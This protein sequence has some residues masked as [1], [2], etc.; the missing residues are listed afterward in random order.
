MSTQMISES[1]RQILGALQIVFKPN[2][3]I[4][5]AS[6]RF[7]KILANCILLIPLI[8]VLQTMAHAGASFTDNFSSYPQN[9]C[10]TDGMNFGPWTEIFGN[11]SPS[12]CVQVQSNG[13]QTW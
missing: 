3:M 9:A 2:G 10:F 11:Y 5:A 1:S 13:S 12:N 7:T 4:E 8:V 6:A